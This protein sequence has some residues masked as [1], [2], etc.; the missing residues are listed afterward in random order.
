[1]DGGCLYFKIGKF[2]IKTSKYMLIKIRNSINNEEISDQ[3]SFLPPPEVGLEKLTGCW[4]LKQVKTNTGTTVTYP[5]RACEFLRIYPNGVFSYIREKPFDEIDLNGYWSSQSNAVVFRNAD[6]STIRC[7]SNQISHLSN[8]TLYLETDEKEF[9]FVKLSKQPDYI[10][11]EPDAFP[12]PSDDWLPN[13]EVA[14]TQPSIS[15]S[16]TLFSQMPSTFYFTNGAGAWGTTLWLNSDGTFV[17]SSYDAD[18][19]D[20]DPERYPNGTLYVCD[21]SG[22]F[23][24]PKKV[25]DY[26]YS[27]QI[28]SMDYADPGIE[29][30]GKGVRN[31][32]TT[33]YGLENAN[34]MTICLPGYPV[35]NLSDEVMSWLTMTE[36]YDSIP[37]TLPF[38]LLINE[39]EQIPFDS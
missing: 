21:F 23:T 19:G 11:N 38:Y 27:V 2:F 32:T 16:E 20:M 17:G 35:E 28:W 14:E 18:M 29:T 15:I 4:Q 34:E 22:A 24:V 13:A 37:E 1:M 5:N 30:F 10:P 12:E 26:T 25:D 9:Q 8:D 36:F 3:P 39:N 6:G 31:I 7:P 33:P